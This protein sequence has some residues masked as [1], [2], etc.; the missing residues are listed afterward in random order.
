MPFDSAT[1][2][3][4]L[5]APKRQS[6][7]TSSLIVTA[8]RQSGVSPFRQLK[9]QVQ[10]NLGPG[11][12]KLNEYYTF[13]LYDPTIS[14]A[15]KKQ[16]V[17]GEANRKL[18]ESLDVYEPNSLH[19]V[20]DNKLNFETLLG[21][22]GFRVTNTQALESKLKTFGNRCTLKT[23]GELEKFLVEEAIFPIFGKPEV[24]SLSIGATYIRER[25]GD[26]LVLGDGQRVP[27]SVLCKEI[28]DKFSNGYLLQ[29][30]LRPHQRLAS[31]SGQAIG[32]VRMVTIKRSETPELLYALWKIP[33]PTAMS[34]N[35][36]QNGSM[37]ACV[38]SEN[39]SVGRCWT[40]ESVE[41]KEIDTHPVSKVE[42][43]NTVLPDWEA[44]K[45]MVQDA[46]SVFPEY[47]LLGWDVA[48]TENGPTLV[49]AN[50]SPLHTLY[51]FAYRRGIRNEDFE[52]IFEDVAKYSQDLLPKSKKKRKR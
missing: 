47:G 20:I 5:P 8:A 9:E 39:G 4:L 35:F 42:F 40:G 43:G 52:P 7:P 30:A 18:N 44:A 33:S 14:P 11:K 23:I 3:Y 26:F 21:A 12:L 25:D 2:N 13:R 19:N 1:N 15:E 27:V 10:L 37:I 51:Q 50:G 31:V 28:F 45:K 41:A 36:W 6:T 46:H 29:H 32:T 49:E 17:G 38:N 22:L 24:S 16:F 34:D 48:L